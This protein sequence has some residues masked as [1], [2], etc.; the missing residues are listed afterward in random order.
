MVSRSKNGLKPHWVGR[1]QQGDQG[2]NYMVLRTVNHLRQGA[3]ERP[4]ELKL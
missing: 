4:G 2:R 3:P 1:Y